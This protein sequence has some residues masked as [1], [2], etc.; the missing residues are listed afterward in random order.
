MKKVLMCGLIAACFM[1]PLSAVAFDMSKINIFKKSAKETV[2]EPTVY[3]P[4]T[5]ATVA[6]TL[7]ILN[8]Q[9][10]ATDTLAQNAFLSVIS[11]LTPQE[12][13]SHIRSQMVSILANSAINDDER[14]K[15]IT[16]LIDMFSSS[17]TD[18]GS[19]IANKIAK[20]PEGQKASL[21]KNLSLLSKSDAKYKEIANE[22]SRIASALSKVSSN[23]A[24]KATI[25]ALK[26][27]AS[28][29]KRSAHALESLMN[30]LSAVSE[31]NGSGA[32]FFGQ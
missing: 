15:Q 11:M 20:M 1:T 6:S 28:S 16:A 13:A 2:K 3:T 5:P 10:A 19:Y 31:S 29:V 17:I 18:N 22:Y 14:G 4:V 24:D 23:K 27:N 26:H 8:K 30:Q 9:L 7:S 32:L 12:E 21:I 25:S